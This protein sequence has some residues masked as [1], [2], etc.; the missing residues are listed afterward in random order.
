MLSSSGSLFVTI[1]LKANENLVQLS[2]YFTVN[3]KVAYFITSIIT[4]LKL[5]FYI[6]LTLV[7]YKMVQKSGHP[8]KEDAY[9]YVFFP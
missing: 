7:M 1:R 5:R 9:E 8:S 4:P 6:K 3:K 2:S